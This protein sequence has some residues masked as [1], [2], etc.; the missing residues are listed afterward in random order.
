MF[1]K[2]CKGYNLTTITLATGERC[3]HKNQFKCSYNIPGKESG[4][5][6]KESSSENGAMYQI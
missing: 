5:L 4:N 1:K 3:E 6:A 2:V